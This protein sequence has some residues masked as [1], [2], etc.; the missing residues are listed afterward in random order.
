M[1]VTWAV[2]V[3]DHAVRRRLSGDGTHFVHRHSA[4]S[5]S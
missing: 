2:F 1:G 5:C 3:V 4:T